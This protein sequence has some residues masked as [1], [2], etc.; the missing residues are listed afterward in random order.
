MHPGTISR[1]LMDDRGYL[2]AFTHGIGINNNMC[3]NYSI[4]PGVDPALR[5]TLAMFNDTYGREAFETLDKVMIKYWKDTYIGA[6]AAQATIEQG[7]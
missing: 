2:T 4:M 6:S 1:T 7:S 5:M 3:A